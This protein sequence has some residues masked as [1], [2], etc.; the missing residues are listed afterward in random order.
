MLATAR[1]AQRALIVL[2]ALVPLLLV[3]LSLTPA[4]L[5]LPFARSRTSQV[6]TL[7]RQLTTW[8]GSLLVSSRER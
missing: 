2:L 7:I 4:L 1:W 5:V 6:L 3:T 8:T